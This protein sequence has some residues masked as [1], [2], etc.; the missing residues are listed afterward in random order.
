[1]SGK[2]HGGKGSNYRKVDGKKYADNWDMIFGKK[3][4]KF[5]TAEEFMNGEDSDESGQDMGNDGADRSE[6]SSGIPPNRD[7]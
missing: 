7:E 2:W 1:M 4:L 6:R 3:D 5:S